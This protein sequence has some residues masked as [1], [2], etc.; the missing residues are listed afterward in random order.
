MTLPT[1]MSLLHSSLIISVIC[2]ILD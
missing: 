2:I 1:T